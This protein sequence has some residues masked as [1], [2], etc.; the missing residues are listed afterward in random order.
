MNFVNELESIKKS[1]TKLQEDYAKE[2]K[3][4]KDDKKIVKIDTAMP[5]KVNPPPVA[6]APDGEEKNDGV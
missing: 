4:K 3:A 6:D 1:I 5:P 2:E